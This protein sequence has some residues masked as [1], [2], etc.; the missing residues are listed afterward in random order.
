M[1]LIPLI[2]L[3]IGAIISTVIFKSKWYY[4]LIITTIGIVCTAG[5][6]AVDYQS[7]TDDTEV[8]SG[9]VINW[10]HKEEYDELVTETHTDSK[11]NTYTDSHWEHHYAKNK[12]ETSDNGW[13]R[14]NKSNDGKRF[15]DSWPNT[16]EELE[17]M[18]PLGS[19]SASSHT[20][21]NKVQ[22]SY[23]VFKHKDIDVKQYTDLPDYP[24]ETHDYLYIDRILGNVPNKQNAL[25]ELNK[26]NTELNKD[27]PDPEKPG[28]TRSWKQVNLIF[29]NVGENKPQDYGFALQD[30]WEGGNKNDF[31]VSFSMNNDGKINWVYPFS[32]S[33]T[34]V[35]KLD[36]RDYMMNLKQINDFTPVVNQVSQMVADKFIR[37]QFADFSYL[38]IDISNTA[39]IIIWVL[40][41]CMLLG[42]IYLLVN[43]IDNI[44]QRKRYGRRGKYIM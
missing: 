41:I 20:Y 31:V 36:V 38:Q 21:E 40:D 22:A 14:V 34:E 1:Y 15:D 4:V 3:I 6:I 30:K 33:D 9:K 10:D 27:V 11:G 37:K 7:Q 19:P 2:I 28:K 43:E 42:Y 26:Q 44:N 24:K 16:T 5:T 29:V 12:I 13:M 23:S 18:W 39:I 17:N 25:I 8:W 32:W 35:L